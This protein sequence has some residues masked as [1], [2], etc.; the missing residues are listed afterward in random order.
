M[1]SSLSLFYVFTLSTLFA[2]VQLSP[3]LILAAQM[4]APLRAQYEP[5]LEPLGLTLDHATKPLSHMDPD[6][7]PSLN[8]DH[9][10]QSGQ[11]D[12]LHG[13]Q[14]SPNGAP[15]PDS[16]SLSTNIDVSTFVDEEEEC[17]VDSQPICF[18]ENPFLVAN[19]KGKGQPAGEQILSGPP[20]GY[21]KQGQLQP[22]LFSKAS[23]LVECGL[24]AAWCVLQR[25]DYCSVHMFQSYGLFVCIE[26]LFL[27]FF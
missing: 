5:S 16:V 24:K 6:S 21:G 15:T 27:T 7:C 23:R 9:V 4:E 14:F 20:V 19:R 2:P 13:S 11:V 26:P 10:L 17:L 3:S 1:V 25:T 8:T 18:S 12:Y 22:W